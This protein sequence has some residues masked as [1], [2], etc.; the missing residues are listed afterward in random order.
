MISVTPSSRS[1]SF[2][3]S[4]VFASSS[5][6]PSN[7]S[8]SSLAISI[9]ALP[10]R[11]GTDAPI[12]VDE[13]LARL[14]RLEIGR[15]QRIDRLDHLVGL[16]RGAE[17]RAERRPAEVDVAAEAQLVELDAVLVDA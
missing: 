8:G 6:L 16:H 17:D 11:L 3:T 2:S 5:I 15:D 10:E 9:D 1:P 14:P 7:G 13:A 4:S 12:G